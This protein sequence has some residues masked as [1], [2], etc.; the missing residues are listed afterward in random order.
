MQHNNLI[1]PFFC[2][3]VYLPQPLPLLDQHLLEI[4]P[5]NIQK[6]K[7][8]KIKQYLKLIN[9]Y[10]DL[11]WTHTVR[12]EAQHYNLLG[13]E[14]ILQKIYWLHYLYKLIHCSPQLTVTENS[15]RKVLDLISWVNA[16]YPSLKLK[17]D[18]LYQSI[19]YETSLTTPQKIAFIFAR[20]QRYKAL[21]AFAQ[22]YPQLEI[23]SHWGKPTNKHWQNLNQLKVLPNF[24]LT[25]KCYDGW[26]KKYQLNSN[27]TIPL[28]MQQF[29]IN[30]TTLTNNPL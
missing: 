25:Q 23:P 16:D 26:L 19:R 18:L 12:V 4:T 27:N 14:S 28:W 10:Q 20:Y 6:L 11:F 15:P 24:Y 1:A 3:S 9:P 5:A 13:T 29:L 17:K 8:N 7:Y 22:Q 21:K 2:T 30:K